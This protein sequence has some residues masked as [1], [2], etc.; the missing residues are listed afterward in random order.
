MLLL[1]ACSSHPLGPPGKDILK[2]KQFA[3]L[4]VE[5]HFY[6]GLYSISGGGYDYRESLWSDS[7]DLY[8]PVLEK[9]GIGREEFVKTLEYYSYNPVQFELIYN[10]VVEELSRR[11]NEAEMEEYERPDTYI[12]PGD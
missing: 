3:D 9:Y 1:N 8:K 10:E 7:M 5:L 11:L 4:L 12:Q 2:P 6:E